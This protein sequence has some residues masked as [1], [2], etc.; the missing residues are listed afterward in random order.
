MQIPARI[1]RSHRLCPTVMPMS[2]FSAGVDDDD[3]VLLHHPSPVHISLDI[4]AFVVSFHH[5]TICDGIVVHVHDDVHHSVDAMHELL[6]LRSNRRSA[7]DCP[8]TFRQ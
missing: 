2:L 7:C 3:D 8:R 1:N 4:F 5:P 6:L